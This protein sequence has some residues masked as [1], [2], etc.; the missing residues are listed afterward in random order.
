MIGREAK[1]LALLAIVG[2]SE[3]ELTMRVTAM[4]HP[5]TGGELDATDARAVRRAAQDL[6][7]T[8]SR[9]AGRLR[10]FRR[11]G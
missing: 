11:V 7:A 8:M 6:L 1:R 9:R 4:E 10:S 2:W 3:A 5:E